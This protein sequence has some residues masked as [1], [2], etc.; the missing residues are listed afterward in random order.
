MP[1]TY[2]AQQYEAVCGLLLKAH[3][4]AV[5]YKAEA[6]QLKSE[7]QAMRAKRRPVTAMQAFSGPPAPDV[8]SAVVKE[9]QRRG[10]R[11]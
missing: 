8:L 9:Q 5:T 7:I 10:Q 1:K 2:T 6:E 4:A 3:K 11:Q